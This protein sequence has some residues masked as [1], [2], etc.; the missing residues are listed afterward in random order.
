VNRPRTVAGALLGV[1][2]DLAD[3]RE[4]GFERYRDDPAGFFGDVLGIEPWS[5]QR[6]ML[7]AVAEHDWV[8]VRSGHRVS[9]TCSA[10]GLALW[11]VATRGPGARVILT[12]PTFT[13]VAQALWRE[14]RHLH[15][16]ARRPLG[17]EVAVLASTGIR[18]ADGRQIIAITAD[19]TEAFQGLAAP[20][21][22]FIVDE[23]SGVEDRIFEAI[24]GNL[25]GGGRMLLISNPTKASGFFFESHNSPRF[26]RIHISSFESPNVTAGKSVIRGLAT[27]EW[28][29]DCARMWGGEEGVLFRIRCKGEFVEARDG[30]MFPADIIARAEGLWASTPATGRLSIGC[31]P[32][33]DGGDGDESGF[34][35]R[36]GMKV[37]RVHARRGL[38]PEAHLVEILGLIGEHRGDSTELPCVLVDRDGLVGH[39]VWVTLDGYLQTHPG[40]F[41]LVGVRGSE[42]A[43]RRPHEIDHVRD[44]LWFNLLDAF[45]HGLAIPAD[46]RLAGD[47]AAIRFDK[48]VNGRAKV[49]RKNIIRRELGRSPDVG[50]A[51]ALA[52]YE[53]LDYSAFVEAQLS[54]QGIGEDLIAR[55]GALDAAGSNE[56]WAERGRGRGGGEWW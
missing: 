2:A 7:R 9:K 40:A 50:D 36:R 52:C 21:I 31:D 1:F 26:E 30:R 12:G 18:W 39:R 53:P 11:F 28:L 4:E 32:A 24:L 51:V 45:Q 41:Q 47:L 55:G 8:T 23:A 27:Q 49:L 25:A 43:K 6:D 44:E 34:A 38:S 13:I 54:S 16:H 22:M 20:E 5:R 46:V 35:C 37:V 42:P 19:K 14:V 17:G 3:E 48:L 15:T 29:V 56:W 33:G 10:A